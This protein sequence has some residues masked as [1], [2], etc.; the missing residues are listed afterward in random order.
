MPE[1]LAP[2]NYLHRRGGKAGGVGPRFQIYAWAQGTAV[3]TPKGEPTPIEAPIVRIW[4]RRLDK[5]SPVPYYDISSSRLQA[6]LLPYLTT[7]SYTGKEFSIRSVGYKPHK[8]L[9]LSVKPLEE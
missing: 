7:Q 6:Q 9:G 3:F 1:L 5:P 4:I 8:T 2:Y